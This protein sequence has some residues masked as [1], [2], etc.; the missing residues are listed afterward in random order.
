MDQDDSAWLEAIG[1]FPL[2]DFACALAQT[3]CREYYLVGVASSR[4][5]SLRTIGLPLR[6]L[7]NSD[8]SAYTWA[9]G[10]E[11]IRTH[12]VVE[13]KRRS[14]VT[15]TKNAAE[16]F[17]PRHSRGF[18]SRGLAQCLRGA[19]DEEHIHLLVL[20][21]WMVLLQCIL[22]RFFPRSSVGNEQDRLIISRAPVPMS[23][24]TL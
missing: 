13:A 8:I 20:M 4:I 19:V 6:P 22:V 3:P 14:S 1:R 15:F 12:G 2:A 7:S 16:C 17:L 5:Q 9:P 18:D 11:E 21:E 24:R 23:L 10:E